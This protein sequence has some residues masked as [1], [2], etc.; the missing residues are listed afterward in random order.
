MV[1][2]GPPGAMLVG[3]LQ[4]LDW[5]QKPTRVINCIGDKT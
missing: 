5:M 4:Y 3:T 2:K 1:T